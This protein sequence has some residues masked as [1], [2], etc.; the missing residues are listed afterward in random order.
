MPITPFIG[1]RISWLMLAR[2]CDFA[3]GGELGPVLGLQQF[4]I[5]PFKVPG[6]LRHL[7]AESTRQTSEATHAQAVPGPCDGHDGQYTKE[8][9]PEGL[10]ETR[11]ECEPGARAGFVPDT[12]VVAGNHAEGVCTR[13]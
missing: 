2:N 8:V 7:L 1:V 11:L 10:M 12:V 9:K 6:A 13:G 5:G 3:C 4:G